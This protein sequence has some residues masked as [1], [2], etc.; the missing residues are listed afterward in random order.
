MQRLRLIAMIAEFLDHDLQRLRRLIDLADL[1]FQ[2]RF[3]LQRLL[4]LEPLRFLFLMHRVRL[5]GTRLFFI[6]PAHFFGPQ[7]RFLFLS[8][9][10]EGFRRGGEPCDLRQNK[11]RGHLINS[12][13]RRADERK[14]F[15]IN[16]ESQGPCFRRGGPGQQDVFRC[17]PLGGVRLQLRILTLFARRLDFLARL[18]EQSGRFGPCGFGR[19]GLALPA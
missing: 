14:I 1:V 5:F 7:G 9:G 19:F 10:R 16:I 13:T 18:V 15:R 11:F 17:F 3:A 6:L 12:Y 8:F 2:S 4:P